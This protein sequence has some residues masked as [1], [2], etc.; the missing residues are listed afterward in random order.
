MHLKSTEV[1]L[2]SRMRSCEAVLRPQCRPQHV[3]LPDFTQIHIEPTTFNQ[4]P[5]WTD[6]C[7]GSYSVLL[8]SL[9]DMYCIESL[10]THLDSRNSGA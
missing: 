6:D 7:C 1:F 3:L 8:S 10:D 5:A 9:R 4:L 2:K